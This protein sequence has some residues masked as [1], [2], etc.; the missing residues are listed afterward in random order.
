MRDKSIVEIPTESERFLADFDHLDTI[1][2]TERWYFSGA[3]F[4]ALSI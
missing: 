4:A 2:G 3:A 1:T